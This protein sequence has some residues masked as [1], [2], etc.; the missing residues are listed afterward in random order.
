MVENVF[1]RMY[2]MTMNAVNPPTETPQ[3]LMGINITK[4]LMRSSTPPAN[5]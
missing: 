1:Q 3:S 2:I 5:I 4:M